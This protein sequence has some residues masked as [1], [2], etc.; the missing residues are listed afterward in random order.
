MEIYQRIKALRERQGLSQEDLANLLGYKDRSTIAKIE[1]GIND[2]TQSKII[3]FA[4]ALNTTPA[5]L[6]GWEDE[7]NKSLSS[8]PDNIMPLPKTKKVP[9]LGEI[10]CGEPIFAAEELDTYMEIDDGLQIDFCLK[11]KGDSMVNARIYDGDIVFIRKQD[12]VENGEIAAVII[13]N[14]ATLKRV[15]YYP[16]ENRVSLV[17]ENPLYP[18]LIYTNEQLEQITI[19]GKAVAFQSKIK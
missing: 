9:L 16:N 7:Q 14:E 3:A 6:M 10:A 15:Y 12:A 17:A 18:P 5:Y 2:I 4:Q 13:G 1:K 8:F 11:C 19:L